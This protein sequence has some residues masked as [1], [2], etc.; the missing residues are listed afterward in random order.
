MTQKPDTK[1]GTNYVN[2]ALREYV[3]WVFTAIS[4]FLGVEVW[5]MSSI[6][7]GLT[8]EVK[9]LA[10]QNSDYADEIAGIRKEISTIREEQVRRSQAVYDVADIAS[11]VKQLEFQVQRNGGG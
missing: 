3:V 7:Q 4:G 9:H 6:M 10:T 8:V 1:T 5:N 2:A 11:R